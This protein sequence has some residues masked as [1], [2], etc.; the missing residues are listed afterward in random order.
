[1]NQ[2]E[3]LLVKA[4]RSGKYQQGTG[5]LKQQCGEDFLLCCLGVASEVYQEVAGDL[6]VL[7]VQ[8]EGKKCVCFDDRIAVLPAKVQQWLGWKSC[9][10]SLDNGSSLTAFNDTLTP[11]SEI[12][13]LIEQGR[14]EKLVA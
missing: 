9:A 5:V 10:G 3:E 13:D 14:V 7:T 1:M 4:L 6:E 11:F 12:A 8:I 2:A